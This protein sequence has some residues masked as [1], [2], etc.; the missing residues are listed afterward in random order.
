MANEGITERL[1]SL[2]VDEP[3]ITD[4][5]KSVKPDP[6][7]GKIGVDALMKY[8]MEGKNPRLTNV[9]QNGAR[10]L[11]QRRQGPIDWSTMNFSTLPIRGNVTWWLKLTRLTDG[12]TLRTPARFMLECMTYGDRIDATRYVD[13]YRLN[14]NS[15]EV[16][17]FVRWCM[18]KPL[19]GQEPCLPTVLIIQH[20]LRKHAPI[21]GP[22]LN[23]LPR[24]FSWAFESED[25][26]QLT[27]SR[28][29][30]SYDISMGRAEECKDEGNKLFNKRDRHGAIL[31][32]T[33][34]IDILMNA[35]RSDPNQKKN[36][37][38][39][40]LL[41]VCSANRAAA[42]LLPDS[43]QTG[44]MEDLHE[45]WKDGE[46]AIC[47]YPSYAKGYVRISTAHQRLGNTQ[48]AKEAIARGLRRTDLRDDAGLVDRLIE[49]QTDGKGLSEDEEEFLA[50]KELILVE[51]DESAKMMKD[52]DGLWRR[53][54]SDHLT[55]LQNRL[56]EP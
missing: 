21:L 19:P 56:S 27:S 37:D 32:Y 43:S 9:L 12:G 44:D 15:D 13:K 53:R 17:N 22:F 20:N 30:F 39:E 3:I 4:I 26:L 54:L 36:R 48:K 29:L 42:Y 41:A 6:V 7:T 35:F 28:S 46:V 10:T 1:R 34:A 2:G 33:T 11:E 49:L 18:A 40:K 45:A 14:P 47:T 31:A 24:P 50:W 52:V 25:L 8:L 5:M 16:L 23:T 51:D 38:A 55:H